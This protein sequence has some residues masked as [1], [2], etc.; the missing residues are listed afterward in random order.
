MTDRPY[1]VR[2]RV[3]RYAGPVFTVVSEEVTLPGGAT[4]TRDVVR[5]AAAA[6]VVALDAAGAV[7]LVRQYRHPVGARLWEVPAGLVDPGEEPAQTAAR[8][9]AEEADLRAGRLDVLLALHTSPGFTDE[10]FTM[11]LARDLAAVP[12]GQRH[13]RRDEEAGLEVRAVPLDD[14]VAMALAGEI[15][16]GPT[17]AGLLAARAARRRGFGGLRPAG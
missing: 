3:G 13:A 17:V 4:V 1:A 14:A 6:G 10:T 11:Y 12:E 16:S 7:V 5:H 9:L 8:E 2:G 15:T